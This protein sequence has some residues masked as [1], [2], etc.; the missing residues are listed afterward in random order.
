[1]L[2][3]DAS[4]LANL[5]KKGKLD[6]FREGA[7]LDLAIYEAANAVLKEALLLKRVSEETAVK[8]LKV[9]GGVLD[10]I[11]VYSLKSVGSLPEALR[12]VYSLATL[13]KL[14][15]YDAAYL[16]A[17]MRLGAT[18]VTDDRKLLEVGRKY[19]QVASSSELL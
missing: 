6:P 13:E 11:P 1:M 4:S 3:F 10:A 17:A 12:E 18:L 9:I 5:I 2:L 15:V 8:W 7:T 16:Y 14:T 19:V